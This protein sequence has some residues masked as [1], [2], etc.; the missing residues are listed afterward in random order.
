MPTG[1]ASNGKSES[2]DMSYSHDA[3]TLSYRA[4]TSEDAALFLELERKIEVP[5]L[6]APADSIE[7]ATKEIAESKLFFV[8]VDGHAIGTVAYRMRPG[9]DAYLSNLAVDPAFHRRG[10][11]R[12]ALR[13][14]FQACEG[15]ARYSLVTHPENAPALALYQSE[16]FAVE[17]RLENY[18]GDGEPRLLLG[19]PNRV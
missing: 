1:S 7:Q 15:A 17:D 4:A 3:L 2:E 12:H 9:G 16:G 13:F 6:Y 18:F 5:R 19:K 10:I 14:F 8:I 11:A